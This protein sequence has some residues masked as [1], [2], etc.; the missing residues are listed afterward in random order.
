MSRTGSTIRWYVDRVQYAEANIAGGINS[1]S[2]FQG[3]FF[4]ILNVAVGGNFVGSPDGSTVFPQQM[5]VDWV[6]VWSN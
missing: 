1:T 5:Q 2:E 6:R 3:P 4:I